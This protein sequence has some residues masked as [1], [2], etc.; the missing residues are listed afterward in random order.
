EAD[1]PG[2]GF[3]FYHFLALSVDTLQFLLF[4]YIQQLNKVSL[5]TSLIGEE[6]PSPRY[7]SQSPD[8]TE[9]SSCHSKNWN[10]YSHQAFVCDHLSDLLELLV[11]PEQLT[12]SF[13]STHSSL[14][15]RE[16]VVALS[17]LI[18]GTVSEAR[19][20]YPLYELALWQPL[21]ADSGFS[22]TSKAFSFYK[23]E[24]WLRACLTGNP[25]GT[26]ACLKSGKRLAWAHQVEGT[27][28][29]AKIACN[30]H[31]A[32]RMYRMVVM[33][34]VY[35]Q[36]LAKSSDTLVGAHVKIHRCNESFIYLLSPLRS[37]TIEKCR[38]STFVLGPVQT[39]LH[40]HSCDNVKV[41]AVCHRL[42]ISSTTDCVFHILT[43]TRPLILSGNQR[44]T[45]APFHTHYPMLEDH[46]ARTGL[47]AVPNYWDNPM[48][49]CQENSSANV[50]R[51]LPPCEFYVFIIPFEMEG[52]TTEIPGGLPSAYRKALGQREKKIQIWQKT[53]KEAR[54]TKDQRKQFQVL[55]ENKFYEW[56]VNTGHRQQ[57][58]SLVPPA[59]GSKQAAG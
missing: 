58:D 45:F 55:V 22:K 9:K 54:L 8:L 34:Q 13:H 28:K 47:A 1:R 15:S 21:H 26:S 14:V 39:A 46:M 6:W 20:I 29:R 42:S 5:R 57:L 18:E 23:L 44:V 3:S 27:T 31:V 51:L 33:S 25:F 52:D 4:L 12:A 43:P 35:K 50:F 2:F 36:T 40:L 41:I 32:P 11:D 24:A 56:L 59:A 30:T 17:F 48:I 38:N 49:V 37:V 53:V 19:K 7:R 10:D 16:A